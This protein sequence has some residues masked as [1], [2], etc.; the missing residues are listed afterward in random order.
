M[1]IANKDVA[2]T[3]LHRRQRLAEL[4]DFPVILWSGCATPRNFPANLFPFRVSSHFL[5]FA[6]SPLEN[7][8]IRL[9][10]GKLELFMDNPH[11]SSILWHG[12]MP[13]RE[14]IAEM[15]GA[16]AAFP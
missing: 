16:D 3:L 7:A 11:P 1:I 15:M 4:I 5:Y 2:D 14:K 9:E 8:A 12:E 10:G 13:T 6:G